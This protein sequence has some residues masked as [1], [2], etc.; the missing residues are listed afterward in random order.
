MSR[1]LRGVA[2]F[3]IVTALPQLAIAQ[4]PDT[5]PPPTNSAGEPIDEI[6]VTG[7][8]Q[9]IKD[10]LDAKR[11]SGN[12]S[13]AIKAE[14]IGKS[15]DQNIA[16]ALQRIT[17]VSINRGESGEGTTIVARGAPAALNNITLNG[18]PLTN[19]GEGSA[20]DLSQFSSDVLSSIEVIKT[21]SASLDEGSLGASIVLNSFSP[22]DSRKNRRVIEIQGRYNSF[23]GN[24]SVPSLSDLAQDHKFSASLSQKFLDNTLGVSIVAVDET[25]TAR[26]DQYDVGQ[27]Y[28]PYNASR[29]R[30]GAINADTGEFITQFDYGDG[31]GLRDIIAHMPQQVRLTNNQ[32]TTDRRTLTGTVQYKPTD[33]LNVKLDVTYASRDTDRRQ[34]EFSAV[35]NIGN[36]DTSNADLQDHLVFDP[37]TFVLVRNIHTA[38]GARNNNREDV[39][40][41]ADV[42]HETEQDTLTIS[43]LVEKTFG[44]FDFSL[45][46]GHSKTDLTTPQ[47]QFTRFR[48][49][50]NRDTGVTLGY[51]CETTPVVCSFVIPNDYINDPTTFSYNTA[52]I[53]EQTGSD[54]AK[55]IYFDT[56]WNQEFGPFTSFEAGLKWS[57]RNKQYDD[58][59]VG[60]NAAATGNI[61]RDNGSTFADFAIPGVVPD[62]FG[63]TLGIDANPP[64][65]NFV[66]LDGGLV[67]SQLNDLGFVPQ[68]R[69]NLRT[70]LDITQDVWGGYVQGNF[71]FFGGDIFGDLGVRVVQTE[72]ES[73]GFS[74]FNYNSFNFANDD[75]VA[76]FGSEAAVLAQLGQ[77]TPNDSPDTQ[78]L[79]TNKYTNVLP[80]INV[81]WLV[82][83]DMMLRFAASQ[84]IARPRINDLRSGFSL[85]ED[86]F[87]TS[88][89]A[90]IGAPSLTPFKSQNFDISYEW[91]FDSNSLFSVALFDKTL[92]DFAETGSFAS[93]YRD[94]RGEYFNADGSVLP[95]GQI[96]FVA[97]FDSVFLPFSGGANQA[98]CMPNREQ[99]L[100]TPVGE[101]FCDEVLVSQSRNG[102][103]GYVRGVEVAFQHNFEYLPGAL[104]HVGVL[105]NYTYSDSRADEEEDEITN[106]F[107]P[108]TPLPETS[109][110]TLNLTGFYEDDRLLMRLAYNYRT[111][112]LV[113]RSTRNNN[114]VWT[115]GFDTLDASGTFKINK[116]FSLNFQ[117]QNLLDTVTRQYVTTGNGDLPAEPFEFGGNKDRTFRLVNTGRIYRA[118]VR[119]TF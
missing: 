95:E 62:N 63:A 22:L 43:G 44:D 9:S 48:N 93:Y 89:R 58:S 88:S 75:N 79:G 11:A 32:V 12:I 104:S 3:A 77:N 40:Q 14:D 78:T 8:R 57:S 10:A 70:S 106:F 45:Q 96:D 72:L 117:A 113:D 85:T 112:Y 109:E 66:G 52:N 35:S 31:N 76:F 2:T 107:F 56:E 41:Y 33:D 21:P 34:N 15:T 36:R 105:A 64:G 71:E 55:S 25:S 86:I 67:I 102:T 65:A 110:H 51:D 94:L 87:N 81:N 13:D 69:R 59:S 118:G 92:K 73:R 20:V 23:V 68:I 53:S 84:T 60:F 54:E 42:R 50:R 38:S 16:E 61:L 80:S 29:F 119:M 99:V 101:G 24:K 28:R 5:T 4:A 18:V 103:G 26:R 116:M 91:Y 111:D 97:S 83:D 74:G 108:E 6:V 27:G 100:E 115:E 37:N 82:R 39:L 114:A 7:F 47:R 30:G 17:G 1:A 90:T 98:G 19:G 49:A 46:A